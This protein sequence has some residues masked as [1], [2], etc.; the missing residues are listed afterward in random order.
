VNRQEK[1]GFDLEPVIDAPDARSD[2]VGAV[3]FLVNCLPLLVNRLARLE[4]LTSMR[5]F[6]VEDLATM[7]GCADSTL[8]G[9]PWKL[10]NYGRPDIGGH[11]RRWL[12]ETVRTWY[13][14]PEDERRREWDR[15]TSK[16]RLQALGRTA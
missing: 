15:M 12:A 8:R 3:A 13:S 16:E 6:T 10:P 1:G 2:L 11:P 9:N 14:R 4:E 7:Q 5:T